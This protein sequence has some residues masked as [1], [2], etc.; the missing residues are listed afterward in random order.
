MTRPLSALLVVV[1]ILAGA[2]PLAAKQPEEKAARVADSSAAVQ[3]ILWND[4]EHKAF[5]N[6]QAYLAKLVKDRGLAEGS[7][8]YDTEASWKKL[9][10][11][12]R[13]RRVEEGEA[14]LKKVFEEISTSGFTGMDQAAM[15]KA[16][17]GE[18]VLKAVAGVM[19]ARGIDDPAQVKAAMDALGK[20]KS[21]LGG[22]DVDWQGI[23]DGDKRGGSGYVDPVKK[24]AGKD[25][26]KAEPGSPFLDSLAAPEVGKVLATKDSFAEFLKESKVAPAALP[27]MFA[28][29]DVLTRAPEAER[30][31]MAHILPTVV[32]FLQDGK[33]ISLSQEE[34]V[35]GMA[36]PGRYDR[37]DMVA[38]TPAI[39]EA[40]PL[41]A[42]KTL[43]H[44]F[45]HIYDMY[46]GRYYTM[47]S[48]LRGFKVAVLY[49]RSIKSAS[50][51]KYS[52]L[53]NSD[54]DDTRGIMRDI[55]SY[56]KAYDAGPQPFYQAVAVGHGYA[57]WQEGVF[58]GR[59]PLREAVDPVTG[60]PRE[61]EA[62]RAMRR[63]AKEDIE[64]L[65]KRQE[66]ARARTPSRERDKELE[67]VSR[68]LLAARSEFNQHDTAVTIR[69]IR[70]R[71]MQSEVQ[72][73]NKKSQAKGDKQPPPFDMSLSVDKDYVVP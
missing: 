54:D 35:L 46:T 22:V 40:D 39:T 19:T 67:K 44:E 71:R 2:G 37:P 3:D 31:E 43:A 50:P 55:E 72:W 7:L 18:D 36:V 8:K 52:E 1:S 70:L 14:F 60:A 4:P 16:V 12:E 11:E 42:G 38:V 66:E 28:M 30:K 9:S 32:R 58:M 26:L 53:L 61:L 27:G 33:S 57:R 13:A 68:D 15:V 49:G 45:Q 10:K 47:D 64:L 17:W 51:D 63:K 62:L 25:Y 59:I 6:Y 56:S 5:F 21:K 69:E 24:L 34:G 20:L 29:Y 65:E 48:E 41:I 73:V 23:F